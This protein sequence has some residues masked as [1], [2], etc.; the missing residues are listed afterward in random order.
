MFR[1]VRSFLD[2]K[3]R[4]DYL[5][6]SLME[7]GHE[8]RF[9]ITTNVSEDA[10]V[11]NDA[12]FEVYTLT[13]GNISA[14]NPRCPK[15]KIVSGATIY[16]ICAYFLFGEKQPSA[17]K[18][19]RWAWFSWYRTVIPNSRLYFPLVTKDDVCLALLPVGSTKMGLAPSRCC[20]RRAP[21][22]EIAR[23]RPRTKGGYIVQRRYSNQ[24][25]IPFRPAPPM[26]DVNRLCRTPQPSSPGS[27]ILEPLWR[28]R[29]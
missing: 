14:K 24:H 22:D 4:Y 25:F 10:K 1:L 18:D 20:R 13:K 5:L 8:R 21:H 12:S 29:R 17:W 16:Q 9:A 26:S 3:R 19:V 28:P 6:V 27:K 15:N 11:G 23:T 7:S 2:T